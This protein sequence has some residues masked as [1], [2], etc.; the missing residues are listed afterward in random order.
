MTPIRTFV[1]LA[2][3]TTVLVGGLSASSALAAADGD[4]SWVQIPERPALPALDYD[5]RPGVLFVPF[6]EVT[7]TAPPNCKDGTTQSNSAKDCSGVVSSETTFPAWGDATAQMDLMTGLQTALDP[8]NVVITNTRPDPYVPYHMLIMSD[9]DDGTSESTVC[10]F[11]GLGCDGVPRNQVAL[12]LGS[13]MNCMER[14]PLGTALYLFGRL[15]GLESITDTTDPMGTPL[16]AMNPATAYQDACTAFTAPDMLNC[17]SAIHAQY[18]NDMDGVQN[19]HQ[20]LLGVY[21][22]RPMDPDTTAPT[23]DSISPADGS[24]ISATESWTV[25]ATASD[26]SGYYVAMWETLEIPPAAEG[27]VPDCAAT[28]RACSVEFMNDYATTGAPW[29]FFSAPAGA[30]P[31]GTYRFRFTAQDMY[32]NKTS[33]EI[34]FTVEGASG[35]STGGNTSA[36]STSTTGAGTSTSG[37]STG[38]IESG[39]G[40]GGDD[41]SGGCS[42]RTSGGG[43][44]AVGAL[45]LLALGAIRRRRS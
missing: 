44:G 37:G 34:S 15:S 19:S 29:D 8:Y 40:A 39:G 14:D 17:V 30:A 38:G 42:C 43:Q 18:C 11:A 20:E 23:I 16:D 36:G 22:P 1:S 2:T 45:A 4:G 25:T 35:G 28:N 9:V 12:V 33:Q 31:G 5:P 6:E 7:L 32:G 13:T 24:T 41:S 27:Q 10:G 3:L 21:G 26:D